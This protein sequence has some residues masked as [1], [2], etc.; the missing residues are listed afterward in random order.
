MTASL[1]L[2][3]VL[4]QGPSG[5]TPVPRL[6]DESL[7]T[8]STVAYP[9]TYRSVWEVFLGPARPVLAAASVATIPEATPLRQSLLWVDE[10]GCV[11]PGYWAGLC[12]HIPVHSSSDVLLASAATFRLG[13]PVLIP[14]GQFRSADVFCYGGECSW[15]WRYGFVSFYTWGDFYGYVVQQQQNLEFVET[16][17]GLQRGKELAEADNVGGSRGS[18]GGGSRNSGFAGPA[19]GGTGN[20]GGAAP[21]TAHAA[22]DYSRP[23][24]S[25]GGNGGASGGGKPGAELP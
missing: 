20:F 8:A 2:A 25:S 18:A 19:Y 1:L 21:S 14:S 15:H 10:S 6:N 3:L 13:D 22:G 9:D 4:L 5:S 24:S 16:S 23:T 11:G 7:P 17:R 12:R